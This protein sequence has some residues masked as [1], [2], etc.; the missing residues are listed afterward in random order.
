MADKPEGIHLKAQAR[1]LLKAWQAAGAQGLNTRQL[2]NFEF[3]KPYQEGGHVERVG[4]W[5]SRKSE[6][7]K[8]GYMFKKKSCAVGFNYVLTGYQA[9]PVAPELPGLGLVEA[10][11]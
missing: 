10:H 6:L 1:A 3:I 2:Q 8:V 11:R 5:R 4:D 9:P 7:K